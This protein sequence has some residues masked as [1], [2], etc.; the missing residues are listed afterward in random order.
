MRFGVA[1]TADAEVTAFAYLADEFGSVVVVGGG[2]VEAFGDVAAQGQHVGYALALESLG[3]AAHLL[4]GGGNAGHVGE[5]G[6]AVLVLD[7]GGNVGREIG[8]AA[9]CAVGHAHE[10]GLEGGNFLHGHAYAFKVLAGLRGEDFKGKRGLGAF[11]DVDDLHGT[12]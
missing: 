4:A 10:V 9:A 2:K 5:C 12:S 6:H 3:H 11:N 7:I 8:S 1:G